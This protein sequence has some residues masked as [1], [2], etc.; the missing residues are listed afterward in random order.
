MKNKL[1][2]LL[3]AG[4]AAGHAQAETF[5]DTRQSSGSGWSLSGIFDSALE[6]TGVAQ[7]TRGVVQTTV[8]TPAP[9]VT[10]YAARYEPQTTSGGVQ[11]GG[12]PMCQNRF[13]V[14]QQSASQYKLPPV[15]RAY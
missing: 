6:Y 12:V 3:C 4:L 9:D 1:I 13:A 15:S 11:T 7:P 14:S 10:P 5:V 2:I 8:A